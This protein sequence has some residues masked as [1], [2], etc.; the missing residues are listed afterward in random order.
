MTK[1]LFI[2]T[3]CFL[4]LGVALTE[5]A[6][7]AKVTNEYKIKAALIYNFLKY[8]EWPD[9]SKAKKLYLG[10]LSEDEDLHKIFKSLEGKLVKSRA[11]TV[12]RLKEKDLLTGSPRRIDV[13]YIPKSKK[14]IA[15]EK[16]LAKL[17]GKA[18]LTIGET[19][20]FLDIGGVIN[21]LKEDNHIRFEIN[22]DTARAAK[23]QLKTTLL[24]LAK[25]VIKKK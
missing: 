15:I 4:L 16:V 17:R 21:F 6:P 23:L 24:K 11:V 1:R 5:T 22:L 19:K 12:V 20:E 18:V 2:L 14:K 8:T 7:P 10:I 25:K 3:S 13:L 9:E